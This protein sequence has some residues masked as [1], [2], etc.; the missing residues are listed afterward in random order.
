MSDQ[1]TTGPERQGS[2]ERCICGH[3]KR[4][5][6]GRRDHETRIPG[7]PLPPWCHAC[8]TE[9]IYCPPDPDNPADNSA[10]TITN[11]QVNEDESVDSELDTCRP[12]DVDGETI[13]VRGAAEMGDE[14]RSALGEV[15]RAAR[16]KMTAEAPQQIGA[17]QNRLRLAH[18]ARR[19]KEHQLDDIRRA[20]CDI[21][22][23]DDDAPYSHADLANVI[24]WNGEARTADATLA[25]LRALAGRWQATVRPGEQHPAA[26]AI[27]NIIDGNGPSVAQ[28]ACTH[29][30]PDPYPQP[31]DQICDCRH[32]GTSYAEARRQRH[33]DGPSIAEAAAVDRNWD[34]E[35]AG[36]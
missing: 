28:T 12:V 33:D 5:H 16:A 24:R 4:D 25:Q 36:E 7:I 34:V 3:T 31:M 8:E 22:F 21:G 23:M 15:V 14:S 29:S 19:A 32:C 30:F 26:A 17:L 10:P 18:Q 9:C 27:L 35:K 6:S 11:E 2:T 13:R 1:T 20:L